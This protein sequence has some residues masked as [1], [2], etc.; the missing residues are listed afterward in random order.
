[1]INMRMLNCTLD[2][3]RKKLKNK[4]IV[5]FG[6]GS[7]IQSIDHSELMELK[8]QFL[9]VIDNNPKDSIKLGDRTLGI[10]S[11]EKVKNEQELVI[12]LTSPV[13]MYDMYCQLVDMGLD[14]SVFCY[15]FPFMQMCSE[16]KIDQKLLRNVISDSENEQK[17]PKVIHCFWFS[18]ERKSDD[19]QRCVDSWSKVL[20]D[21]QIKEWNMSNYDW[22]RHPFMER[23]IKLEAWA[24]ASD[25]AR[26]QVLQEYGGIYL[27]MDV[28]VFKPFDD[29]LCNNAILAFSNHVMVD[30]AVLGSRRGNPLISDL[31]HLYDYVELPVEGK[32]F[33]AFFQPVFVR[34]VLCRHG[35]KM[36]GSLQKVD[37]ATVFPN[38][39]FMPQDYVLFRPY[40]TSVYNYCIHHDNF[41]WSF[42]TENKREKKI[43]GNN[44]LWKE[45]EGDSIEEN[46]EL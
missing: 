27:D 32:E 31:M 28:E 7:W 24:F 14:D 21:Y 19:Y 35:I 37:N 29:L 18:G 4:R 15:A 42:S 43:R 36:N 23:A 25:Y 17:I 46:K 12:I 16:N 3:A 34:E 39:F 33:A 30:L 13:Y 11:P 40:K 41:G 22:H 10:Y 8:D 1:M 5:F 45:I 44:L 9:Y 2:E 38:V 26:L 6:G 20:S